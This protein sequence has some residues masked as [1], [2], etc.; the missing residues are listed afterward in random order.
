M[1]F[2]FRLLELP[3]HPFILYPIRLYYL[4]SWLNL[5]Q[6]PPLPIGIFSRVIVKEIPPKMAPAMQLRKPLTFVV[7]EI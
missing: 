3:E 1:E 7:L 2:C 5:Q 4:L 6:Y